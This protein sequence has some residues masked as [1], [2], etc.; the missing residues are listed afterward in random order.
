M[1]TPIK[2]SRQPELQNPS[3]VVGWSADAGKLGAKVTDYLNR[4]LGVKASARLNQ[5]SSPL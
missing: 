5:Q 3:L 4:K 2:F 1:K